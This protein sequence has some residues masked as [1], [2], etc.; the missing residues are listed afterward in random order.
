MPSFSR[1]TFLSWL[2]GVATAAGLA[3]RGAAQTPAEGHHDLDE[4]RQGPT[5]DAAVV[6]QL[7]EVVL[8]ASELGR[9]GVARVSRAFTQWVA[10]HR[11]GAELV[12]P[13]GSATIRYTGESPASRWRDQLVALQSAARARHARGFTDLTI[14][15]RRALVTA[16]LAAERTDRMPNALAANHVAIALVAFFYETP[17][18]T[19]LCYAARIGRNQC[20]PLIHSARAPLPLRGPAR[21]AAA[22]RAPDSATAGDELA[23]P[24]QG[25]ERAP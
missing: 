11:R 24:R 25:L 20:R 16:A 21:G 18:A 6:T 13:Y 22:R 12:H 4:S 7:G 9:A 8:P 15:Q 17:E 3:P 14:A 10:G 5:L 19:D 2:G 1:R 23:G